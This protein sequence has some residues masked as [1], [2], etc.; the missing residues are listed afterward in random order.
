MDTLTLSVLIQNGMNFGL[1][2]FT[3]GHVSTLFDK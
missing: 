2:E 3:N 1:E